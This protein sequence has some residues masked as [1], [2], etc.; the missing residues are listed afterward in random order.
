[1]KTKTKQ[2]NK[3]KLKWVKGK[4][5]E[6]LTKDINSDQV[7]YGLIPTEGGGPETEILQQS[8]V[9]LKQRYFHISHSKARDCP[10]SRWVGI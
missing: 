3:Q 2:T 9:P 5:K 6:G 4:N 7:Y 1:M 8:F 10:Q